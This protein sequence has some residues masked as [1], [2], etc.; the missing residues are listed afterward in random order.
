MR[1]KK[2]KSVKELQDQIDQYFAHCKETE[3]IPTICGLALALDCDRKTLLNYETLKGYERFF[4]TI[5][6][7]KL[8]IENGIEQRLL[9]GRNPAGTIF[10]LKNNFGWK[11][12]QEVSGTF[13][14]EDAFKALDD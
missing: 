12:K 2:F 7:A 13:T 9:K 1:P 14:I 10:N 8:R 4:L 11:D 5:K 6:K 3:E